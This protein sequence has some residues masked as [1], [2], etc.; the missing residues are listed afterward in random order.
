MTKQQYLSVKAIN[1][2]DDFRLWVMFSDGIEKI[3]SMKPYLHQQ[4]FQPLKDVAIFN[5]VQLDHGIPVW[6][7]GEIDIAPARLYVD[8]EIVFSDPKVKREFLE[9]LR[10]PFAECIPASEVEW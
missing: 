3:F 6:L 10:T 9:G 5:R 8:G 2:L 1:P 7:D 4:A